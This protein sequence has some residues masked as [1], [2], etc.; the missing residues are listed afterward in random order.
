MNESQQE[1]KSVWNLFVNIFYNLA[2]PF[3]FSL[4]FTV[5]LHFFAVFCFF[6]QF[7]QGLFVSSP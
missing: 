7:F 6:D 2:Y 5:K 3:D 1:F 4:S